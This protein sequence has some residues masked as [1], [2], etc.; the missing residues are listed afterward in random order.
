MMC[1]KSLR[2]RRP[3][4]SADLGVSL[5][6]S[7]KDAGLW[8]QT[9]AKHVLWYIYL[10]LIDLF[11][12]QS[13]SFSG[14][15]GPESVWQN[16]TWQGETEAVHVRSG[17]ELKVVQSCFST[18]FYLNFLIAKWLT[19]FGSRRTSVSKLRLWGRKWRKAQWEINW[20]WP[21]TSSQGCASWLMK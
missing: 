1:K 10:T 9:W 13:V 2:R 8:I 11:L 3:T 17:T 6:S 14:K 18:C 4:L 7:T 20:N 15:Q 19:V 5:R 16:Q 21:R 12:F